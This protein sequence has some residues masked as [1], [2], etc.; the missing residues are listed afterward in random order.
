[1]NAAERRTELLK[2]IAASHKPLS[3][4]ALAMQLG[5]SR[6]VIVTDIAIL[7][8]AGNDILATNRGYMIN[9]E[10]SVSR[11]FKV[12]HSDDDIETE[13]NIVVDLGG[14]VENVF[15]WH[16]IYG[17][18]EAPLNISSRRNVKEYIESLKSGRSSPLKNVTSQYHYHEITADSNRIL[19][20]IEDA[21]KESGFLVTD[22]R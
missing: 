13:L 18:I 17:K 12:V 16:K 20:L 11:I 10:K 22:E 4:S 9:G 14:T 15:V 7:K 8:A 5:V 19:D 21:L 1:M 6:Q 2:M 3:G